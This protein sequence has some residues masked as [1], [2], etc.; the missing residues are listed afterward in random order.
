MQERYSYFY[1]ILGILIVFFVP[2]TL[3]LYIG[4]VCISFNSYGAF[5]FN[6]DANFEVLA[7]INIVIY[8]AYIYVI[9]REFNNCSLR[10]GP[11][12]AQ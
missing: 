2:K 4:L 6:F 9:N 5:L 11:T 12:H 1:E 10:K 7:G 3:P 8:L